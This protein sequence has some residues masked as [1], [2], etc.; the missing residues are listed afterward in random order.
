M[1]GSYVNGGVGSARTEEEFSCVFV[2]SGY[3]VTNGERVGAGRG[4]LAEAEGLSADDLPREY[5]RLDFSERELLRLFGE[6]GIRPD[7]GS[8]A[9]SDEEELAE[10]ARFFFRRGS[11]VLSSERGMGMAHLLLSYVERAGERDETAADGYVK[12]TEEYIEAHLA[13]S[14]QVDAMAEEMGISRGYLRNIFFEVHGMS[15][16]E[17]LTRARIR[18]AEELLRDGERS[19]TEVA[20]Q[21]GYGDVLQFSRIFKKHT[22]LSPSAYREARGVSVMRRREE[23]TATA[24]A[25]T[26]IP[27]KEEPAEV[28]KRRAKDPVWLF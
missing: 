5:V 17:Y 16:R 24:P 1:I 6:Y 14:I 7:G 27:T 13:D 21:V 3:A 25:V 19:V 20:A 4:F 12:R 26:P 11:R 10:S 28:P 18:R 2:L 15:P 23:R 22:G 9:L 8:F